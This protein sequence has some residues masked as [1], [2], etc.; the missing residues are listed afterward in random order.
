MKKLLLFT[1]VTLMLLPACEPDDSSSL[2]SKKNVAVQCKGT[3]QKGKRCKRKT[4]NSSGYC[5][6]HKP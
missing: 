5:W 4:T 2:N 1:L 3:T 6:Q